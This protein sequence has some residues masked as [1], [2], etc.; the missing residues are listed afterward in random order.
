MT[1][2][3]DP[4][5]NAASSSQLLPATLVCERCQ[6]VMITRGMSPGQ[7][8]RCGRCGN[9]T[10][11]GTDDNVGTHRLAWRSFWLGLASIL[12]LFLTGIPAV[13]YGIRGLLRMRFVRSKTSDR[14]AAVAGTMMGGI[15]GVLIGVPL[16][17]AVAMG[18]LAIWTSERVT[19]PVAIQQ[20]LDEVMS[21]DLPEDLV[22]VRSVHVLNSQN[23]FDFADDD[24]VEDRTIFIRL[25]YHT[26]AM[27]MQNG[28]VLKNLESHKV[29]SPNRRISEKSQTYT[30]DIN[31]H[32]TKVRQRVYLADRKNDES[33]PT[34]TVGPETYHHYYALFPENGNFYGFSLT[35]NMDR[36]PM[37]LEQVKQ[38]AQSIKPCAIVKE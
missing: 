19:D 34:A 8:L 14:V 12:L 23:M 10:R 28:F 20:R 35:I 17:A 16:V 37:S 36:R 25:L 30:W 5:E 18:A 13:Y 31:G 29:P 3:K 32:E 2:V 15:F 26:H 24:E 11:F 6:A 7:R 27:A 38:L 22:G 4:P 9:L 33:D 1:T 21:V